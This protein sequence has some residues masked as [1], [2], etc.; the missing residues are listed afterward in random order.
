MTA[1]KADRFLRDLAAPA[2]VSLRAE[3]VALVVAHPDDETIGAGGQLL[4]LRGVTLV[5]ATDGSPKAHPQHQAY[6]RQRR[7]ELAAAVALA[8][9]PRDAMISLGFVDQDASFHL[10]ELARRLAALFEERNI[11]IVVTHAYEGGHPDHDAV[12]FAV[13]AARRLMVHR[14]ADPPDV[15]EMPLYHRGATGMVAQQFVPADVPTVEVPL[16]DAA[17]AVKGRML[18]AHA[19]QA[20][21]LTRFDSR[22]ERFRIAPSYD[23]WVLPNGGSLHY[24]SA[25]WGMTGERW[26]ELVAAASR[27]LGR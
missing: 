2:V 14:G 20:E 12:S 7:H 22:V 1:L 23:F 9:V 4:R 11:E 8:G 26:R 19:S 5:H 15:I 6:A 17:W 27:E 3:H 21:V 10:A 18:A 24:E 13:D 25:D 16:S